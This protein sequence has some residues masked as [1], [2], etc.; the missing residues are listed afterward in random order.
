MN[1]VKYYGKIETSFQHSKILRIRNTEWKDDVVIARTDT[2]VYTFHSDE[3]CVS[4]CNLTGPSWK[5]SDVFNVVRGVVDSS[6]FKCIDKSFIFESEID[7]GVGGPELLHWL[8]IKSSRDDVL[9]NE[10]EPELN[11][12]LIVH[13]STFN[14]VSIT[15]YI[16]LGG[17]IVHV[18]VPKINMEATFAE[19][20][21]SLVGRIFEDLLVCNKKH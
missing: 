5:K 20:E 13:F 17:R 7:L 9:F 10:Y 11:D 15:S 6:Y 8:L 18:C 1:L 3:R 16:Y 19:E 12:A 2:T 4:I 14:N 21:A